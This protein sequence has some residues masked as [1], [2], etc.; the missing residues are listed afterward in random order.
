MESLTLPAMLFDALLRHAVESPDQEVCGL[1]AADA[2]GVC[3]LYRIPNIAE[4]PET[5]FFMQPDTQIQAMRQMRQY[6][7][8]LCGIY[9]SHPHSAAIPS[10]RDRNMA[11]YP[12]T[13]Y[14]IVSLEKS[15]PECLA[16]FYD[17][18]DFTP[19]P[20]QRSAP[21]KAK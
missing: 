20:L 13:A 3:S 2:S 14:L 21:Q 1:L 9:H 15:E 10:D 19:I 12:G 7:E 16:Y 4:E 11:A 6:G 18:E 8:R 17:G 5:S